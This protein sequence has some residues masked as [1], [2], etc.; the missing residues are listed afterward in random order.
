VNL[1]FFK[2]F[3]KIFSF[4]RGGFFFSSK[5]KNKLKID[6]NVFLLS[7]ISSL[8]YRLGFFNKKLFTEKKKIPDFYLNFSKNVNLSFFSFVNNDFDSLNNSNKIKTCLFFF[9]NLFFDRNYFRLSFF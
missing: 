8:I 4:F 2:F 9:L 6:E 7:K 3:F 1:F 5:I